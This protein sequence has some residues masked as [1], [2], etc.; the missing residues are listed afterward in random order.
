MTMDNQKL[1]N[2]LKVIKEGRESELNNIPSKVRGE[3]LDFAK[4]EGL[5]DGLTKTK[6][7]YIGNPRITLMGI[8][9]FEENKSSTKFYNTLKEIRDWI[10]GY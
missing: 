6:D 9:Y 2:V 1:L 3:Y 7:G 10:P 8:K 4:K 5:V